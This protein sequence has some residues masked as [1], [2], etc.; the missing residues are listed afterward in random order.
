M[1]GLNKWLF[2]SYYLCFLC[3]FY[4]FLCVETILLTFIKSW[5]HVDF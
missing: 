3:V 2:L 4:V 1:H 5:L